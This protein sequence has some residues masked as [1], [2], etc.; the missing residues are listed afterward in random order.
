[1]NLFEMEITYE[2]DDTGASVIG[3]HFFDGKSRTS[4]F[5]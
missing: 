4:P 2:W 3:L 5:S 1:M